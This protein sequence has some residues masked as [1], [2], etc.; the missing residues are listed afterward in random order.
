MNQLQ[1]VSL[2]YHGHDVYSVN[3]FSSYHY[4]IFLIRD[5]VM[6]SANY[7]PSQT[8]AIWQSHLELFYIGFITSVGHKYPLHFLPKCLEG[9]F[10]QKGSYAM[11]VKNED[12][13]IPFNQIS[14][15]FYQSLT[16]HVHPL[17]SICVSMHSCLWSLALVKVY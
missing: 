9:I 8:S 3:P 17:I 14:L 16:H 11:F 10:V 15:S 6:K 4:I 12:Y 1:L 5:D 2:I 13:F 7:P